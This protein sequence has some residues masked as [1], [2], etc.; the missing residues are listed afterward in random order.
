MPNYSLITVLF[1]T[2]LI[3]RYHLPLKPL[4]IFVIFWW[5]LFK[6]SPANLLPRGSSL[7]FRYNSLCF[8]ILFFFCCLNTATEK[9][10]CF[11]SIFGWKLNAH[12]AE[13]WFWQ[14]VNTQHAL[15]TNNRFRCKKV[16]ALSWLLK[17]ILENT[18]VALEIC[19]MSWGKGCQNLY[20]KRKIFEIHNRSTI[21]PH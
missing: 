21:F 8:S 10:Y 16:C 18:S 1:S 11:L 14:N 13:K 12:I 5:I 2:P 9:P 7:H 15:G 4:C 19:L 3:F 17:W 6:K 20:L